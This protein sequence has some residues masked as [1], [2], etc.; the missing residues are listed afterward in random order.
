MV[1]VEQ[2]RNPNAES[3]LDIDVTRA[4]VVL[5]ITTCISGH[6]SR[7]GG[8]SLTHQCGWHRA[9]SIRVSRSWTAPKAIQIMTYC[10]EVKQ[11]LT[12]Y[13]KHSLQWESSYEPPQR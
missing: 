3:L 4:G 7:G 6:P 13:T 9:L 1:L 2:E 5:S 8:R 11:D 10:Y 12:S